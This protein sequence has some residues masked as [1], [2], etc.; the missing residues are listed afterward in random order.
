MFELHMDNACRTGDVTNMKM[1]EYSTKKDSVI[2]VGTNIRVGTA[3]ICRVL[4]R[5]ILTNLEPAR[6]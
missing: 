2:K 4:V 1:R 6:L 3:H 5:G